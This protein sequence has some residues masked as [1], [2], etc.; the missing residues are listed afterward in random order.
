MTK[1]S[2]P[3]ELS[4]AAINISTHGRSAFF[5]PLSPARAETPSAT[6]PHPIMKVA[7]DFHDSARHST[8]ASKAQTNCFIDHDYERLTRFWPERNPVELAIYLLPT[9][10]IFRPGH[11]IRVNVTGADGQHG[12]TPALNPAPTVSVH[13][14][15]KY[16][17]SITLPIIPPDAV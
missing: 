8:N 7:V 3:F 14:N 6:N 4:L 9:S 15:S 5:V 17:S 11:R 1:H 16:V 2:Q 12:G 10:Y 13:R